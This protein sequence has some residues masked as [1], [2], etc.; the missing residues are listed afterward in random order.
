MKRF[1]SVF[2][3]CIYISCAYAQSYYMHEVAE[4]AGYKNS[5]N[6]FLSIISLIIFVLLLILFIPLIIRNK[7]DD[8]KFNQKYKSRQTIL[9]EEAKYVLSLELH[10]KI[11]LEI[12]QNSAWKNWF[13]QGYIDGVGKEIHT[14]SSTQEQLEHNWEAPAKRH[15]ESVRVELVGGSRDMA[16]SAYKA[17]YNEG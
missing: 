2:V 5:G 16:L 3:F 13:I 1:C 15:I 10:N 6:S 14:Q 17:G 8:Y 9:T 12:Q 7:I 11:Y 4:D